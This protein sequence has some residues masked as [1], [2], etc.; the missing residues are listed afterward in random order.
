MRLG[1]V[2]EQRCEVIAGAGNTCLGDALAV[3]VRIEPAG[4]HVLVESLDR[5]VSFVIADAD[6]GRG[7]HGHHGA[8]PDGPPASAICK[9]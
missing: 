2:R 8:P 1:Q 7:A 6:S 9:R 3:F 4:T 5:G